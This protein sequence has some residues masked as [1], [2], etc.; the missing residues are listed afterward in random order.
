[1]A[2][3]K[4]ADVPEVRHLDTGVLLRIGFASA[5]SHLSNKLLFQP[6]ID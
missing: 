6:D 1:M 5:H 3:T 4:Q 2:G